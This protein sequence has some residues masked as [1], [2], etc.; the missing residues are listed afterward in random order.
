MPD[1]SPQPRGP[2]VRT[3]LNFDWAFAEGDPQGAEAPCFDDAS[4]QIVHLPHDWSVRGPFDP[5]VE[6][7]GANGYRPRG[8][9]WYRKR[10]PTP[11]GMAGRRAFV[12]FEGVYMA[13]DVWL[14]GT[15]LGKRYNGYLGFHL[16]LTPHLRPEGEENVLA[17]R[18]DNSVP[19]TS[20][21]YTGSGIY[22]HAWLVATGEVHVLPWGTRVTTPR[23]TGDAATVAVETEVANASPERRLCELHT[24]I[25]DS[26]GAT[27]AEA[28]GRAPVASG[29]T[30][31]FHQ[32]LEVATPRLWSPETPQ[33][34]T[35]VSTLSDERGEQDAYRTPFGIREITLHP[36][37]G[38]LVNGAKVI[39][40]GVNI[41]HDLGCLGAAAFDRAIERRLA[42]LKRMGCN[43]VRLS[44]NP[45]APALLDLC[46]R[47]GILVFD[48]AFDKWT[49]QYN[50]GMAPFEDTW[51][52]DLR[53]WLARDR[54]HPCVF[55]WSVGNEVAEHQFEAEKGYGVDQLEAM[56]RFV[57]DHEPTRKV[58]C[59][60]F[61]AREGGVRLD[62]ERY[63]GCEPAEM[64]FHMDVVSANYMSEFFARDH[65]T[66][67]QLIL[68]LSEAWT[69][70]G[71]KAWFSYDKA[72]AVGQFYWSGVDYIGEAGAWPRKGWAY[73]PI[74]LCGFRKP[75]S[76][77]IEATYSSRPMVHVAV[78]DTRPGSRALWSD[79]KWASEPM[80]SHW[81]WP[82][83]GTLKLATYTNCETV[84]LLLNG[85]SLG[86]RRLADCP[87]MLME[88]DVPFEPGT[89]KAVARNAGNLAAA[90]ELT[91]AG[92][93]AS[94]VLRPDRL[95]LDADGL[96]LA[97]V[98]VLVTDSQGLR[99]PDAD[100]EIRF[101]VTGAGTNAGVDNG[102]LNSDEP[103]QAECRRAFKGRAL[104]VVR[105]GRTPGVAA[106][107]AEA[108]GLA[109]ATLELP[110]GHTSP[111]ACA[112]S[113][114]S[115]SP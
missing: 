51:R 110:V 112:A 93:A 76:Y 49:P 62:D 56:V 68:L 90:H 6:G 113:Q 73:A 57:H 1:E 75:I 4:W 74:D 43:A 104:L 60:L 63:P 28:V 102:N 54:N 18:V 23:I 78:Y 34:Y 92:E 27:V 101:T 65:E 88:W 13:P 24:T 97:H 87:E 52:S 79:V 80:A 26:V 47:M 91:T 44:H 31:L 8:I 30:A 39:A 15:H 71:A 48:E 41:H 3:R 46:D 21:W 64:A 38:L 69:H 86:V 45:H 12:E 83:G 95:S 89:L 96:D 55:L 59:A 114:K 61:P 98:A 37:S 50:G 72:Y 66:Y 7:G 108:N 2:R 17:V 81:N 111:E 109:P 67:P 94:I 35:A 19:G 33:L 107:R 103:W 36:D 42:I 99:V 106:I 105:A 40:K 14:N 115:G 9:G 29:E 70:G 16:D 82:A 77:Y 58:T 100:H 85:R 25:L 32:E 53:D 11:A 10:F 5:D 22:R 84:E 20:R